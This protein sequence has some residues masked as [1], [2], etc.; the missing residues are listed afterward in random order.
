MSLTDGSCA[1]LYLLPGHRRRGKPGMVNRDFNFKVSAWNRHK[2]L[3]NSTNDKQ[4]EGI[5]LVISTILWFWLWSGLQVA[6][7]SAHPSWF[8]FH[9]SALCSAPEADFYAMHLLGSFALWFLIG[10]DH[11]KSLA[12]VWRVKRRKMLR[13]LFY[14][15]FLAGLHLLEA[16][17]FSSRSKALIRQAS[18]IATTVS[19]LWMEMASLWWYTQGPSPPFVDFF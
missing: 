19:S 12:T 17:F 7:A 15:S 10:F 11:C 4:M 8:S 16:E 1:L 9:L 18:S 6:I 13:Y 2:D 5:L 3:V 14:G